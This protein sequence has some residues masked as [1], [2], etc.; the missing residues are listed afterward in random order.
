MTENLATSSQELRDPI[1]PE[2]RWLPGAWSKPVSLS[3]TEQ[4]VSVN[5][6]VSRH[7]QLITDTQHANIS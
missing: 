1:H 2:V 6:R 4:A 7:S 5:R 3:Q